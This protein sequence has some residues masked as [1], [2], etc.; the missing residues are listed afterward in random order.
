MWYFGERSVLRQPE[1]KISFNPDTDNTYFAMHLEINVKRRGRFHRVSKARIF[2][3]HPLKAGIY[4]VTVMVVA[5]ICITA[6]I[7]LLFVYFYGGDYSL[8]L[9]TLLPGGLLG[10]FFLIMERWL[11]QIKEYMFPG[12]GKLLTAF[13]LFFLHIIGYIALSSLIF[14]YPLGCIME[15]FWGIPGLV[16]EY[17]LF[18]VNFFIVLALLSWLRNVR[19]SPYRCF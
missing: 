8:V 18:S 13:L 17:N 3:G 6:I 5:Y 12:M 16:A 1:F 9:W 11:G 2:A 4:P 15:K 10:Y 7:S 19:T 14:S